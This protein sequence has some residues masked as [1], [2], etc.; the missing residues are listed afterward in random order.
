MLKT[1]V[2]VAHEIEKEYDAKRAEQILA[3]GISVRVRVGTPGVITIKKQRLNG[4]K[5]TRITGFEPVIPFVEGLERTIRA[6]RRHYQNLQR[7]SL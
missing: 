7:R 5:L 3:N 6:Y 2:Q 1:V 4:D